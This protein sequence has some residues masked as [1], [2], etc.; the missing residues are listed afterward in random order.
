MNPAIA[1]RIPLVCRP[2]PPGIPLAE[3]L[4]QLTA[5]ALEPD[6][7][8]HTQ[9]VARASGVLNFAALI[10]SDV[11]LP[12]L[13]ADLCWRQYKIFAE[14][15]GLSE[16]IAVMALM[17]VVNI[18]RLLIR[19][20]DGHSAFEVLQHV[21]R[22]AQWRGTAV[23]RGRDIDLSPLTRTAADHRTICT[24]LWGT[25]LVDGARALARACRWTEAAETMAAHRGIGNRLLDG[26]QIMIMSLMEQGLPQQATAMIESSVPAEPWE[27]TIAALLRIY[28]QPNT[29]PTSPVELDDAIRETLALITQPE[30][31]TVA[32]RARVGL[33]ALDLTADELLPKA[34]HLRDTVIDLG[35][36][37]AYAARDIL[38]HAATRSQMT[39]QQ[40]QELTSVLAAAG[41]GARNLPP[42]HWDAL[43]AAV[44]IAEDLL[45]SLLSRDPPDRG[46]AHP[47]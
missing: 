42:V 5:L 23:V 10:A 24:E 13:A 8:D 12:D 17:P 31:T 20:G 45:R 22:A 39:H 33:T 41:L 21:Y 46:R 40:E 27:N 18:A 26:R 47:R 43:T 44:H 4:A 7:A 9:L 3:R 11:G 14:A 36:S 16:D 15:G 29:S 30:P 19:E 1:S 32:F 2:K 38:E 25:L 34:R 6:G 35:A 37:D 28:C